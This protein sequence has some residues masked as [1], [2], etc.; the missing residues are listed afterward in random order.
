MILLSLKKKRGGRE[1]RSNDAQDQT[2]V[3][4]DEA[5]GEKRPPWGN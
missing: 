4:K 1:R 3:K 5:E 2:W